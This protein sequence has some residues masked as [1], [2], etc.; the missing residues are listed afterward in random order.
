[1]ADIRQKTYREE[2]GIAPAAE[3]SRN[4]M[5]E[6]RS[7]IEN[8]TDINI[9]KE[10]F[11]KGHREGYTESR[12]ISLDEAFEDL[13]KNFKECLYGEHKENDISKKTDRHEKKMDALDLKKMKTPSRQNVMTDTGK[14]SAKITEKTVSLAEKAIGSTKTGKVVTGV[15]S[16]SNPVTAA[17]SVA[18]KAVKRIH[19]KFQEM[20]Q[21]AETAARS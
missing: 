16:K 21:Q 4:E 17:V 20:Q 1:M 15:I 9:N 3:Y 11:T 19:E 6:N 5:S 18:F 13:T 7:V 12:K 2:T 8:M 14:K 10:W